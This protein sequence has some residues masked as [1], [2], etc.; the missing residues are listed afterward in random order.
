[1]STTSRPVWG[2]DVPISM[3][4]PVPAEETVLVDMY[5]LGMTQFRLVHQLTAREYEALSVPVWQPEDPH[6]DVVFDDE[7][8]D[9][10]GPPAGTP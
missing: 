6:Q 2:A 8:I 10:A 1:M 7:S 9:R 5:G 3:P 4:L